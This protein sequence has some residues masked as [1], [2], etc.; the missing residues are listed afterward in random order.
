MQIDTEELLN[1]I[2]ES[3]DEIKYVKSDDIPN[4]DLYMDQVTTLLDKNLRRNPRRHNE[5]RKEDEK[6]MTKTMINNYAKNDLLPAPVKKKYSREHVLMLIFIYYYKGILSINDVQ[7]LFNPITEKYFNT[8]DEFDLK[9]I[10]DEVFKQGY[11]QVDMLKEH[12]KAEYQRAMDTFTDAPQEDRDYL[13]IFS[14]ICFLGL[15]VYMKRTIIEQLIDEVDDV[16]QNDNTNTGKE[17]P[18]L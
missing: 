10:Y 6:I 11:T 3:F 13:K 4:I 9:D 14:L 15:D 2:M 17:N 18:R 5:S 16:L 12:V 1:K 7:K 8:D